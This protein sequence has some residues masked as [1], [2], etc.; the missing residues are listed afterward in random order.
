MCQRSDLRQ[1][2]SRQAPHFVVHGVSA[3][4]VASPFVPRGE[5]RRRPHGRWRSA[6]RRYALRPLLCAGFAA[7][8]WFV[9]LGG[10]LDGVRDPLDK[11]PDFLPVDQAFAFTATLEAGRVVGRWRMSPGYYLYRH[12]FELLPSAG[13]VLGPLETPPGKRI[14]DATF[15]ATEVY[16]HEAQ[17]SAPIRARPAD[18]QVTMRFV[19]QGCSAAGLCYPPQRRTV[20]FGGKAVQQLPAGDPAAQRRNSTE[21]G[22]A[23]RS[24]RIEHPTTMSRS[25]V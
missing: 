12:R 16:Y 4:T 23:S 24:T 14:K 10:P 6:V 13:L 15:G 19:Y 8:P 11:A 2:A 21:A 3:P 25:S 20:T 17:V 18:G 7:A 1:C 5:P 9:A 22:V